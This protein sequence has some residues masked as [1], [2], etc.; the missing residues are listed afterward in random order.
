MTVTARLSSCVT[1]P[2]PARG[3]VREL[4]AGLAPEEVFTSRERRLC[5]QRRGLASWAGRF[6][7]KQAVLDVLGEPGLWTGVEILP[8]ATGLCP[9]PLRCT[10]SHPPVALIT[11]EPAARLAPGERVLVSISHADGVAVALAVRTATPPPD[12]TR[13]ASI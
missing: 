4:V 1:L 8:A 2:F 13:T 12:G 5:A 3:S 9:D 10:A 6:A 11:G 7:A